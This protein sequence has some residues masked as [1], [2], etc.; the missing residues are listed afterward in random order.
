MNSYPKLTCAIAAILGGG[1]VG[2]AH[3]AQGADSEAAV[4]DSIEEVVVTAERRT[5][6]IQDVP[7][8]IQALTAET[9]TQ[10]DVQTMDDIVKFLPNVTIAGWGPGQG[11]I[12]MRGLSVGLLGDQSG[13]SIGFYPNVAI[14][15]DEQSG[16]MPERNLDIYAADLERVEV[17]EGPQGTLFGGSAE[18]G[19]V[20]YI[21][22][23]PKLDV[24]EG[25][26]SG[27]YGTTAH[28][29]PNSGM[30]AVLN[31]PLIENTLAVRG[32]IY[33][34]SRGGYINNVPGTFTRNCNDFG[35]GHA[36]GIPTYEN[37]C[38]TGA[39]VALGGN[40]SN[41][42]YPQIPGAIHWSNGQ[43]VANA[44]NPVTYTGIR[45]EALWKINDAWDVLLSQMNQNMNA[46]GVF[47]QMPKSDDGVPLGEWEVTNFVPTYDHDKF[48]ASSV[49]VNGLIGPLKALYSGGFVDRNVDQAGDYT[50]YSRGYAADYYNC[51]SHVSACYS[52]AAG[53]NDIT[54][55]TH[56]SHELRLSSPDDWRDR[57]VA[58]AY[59][60]ENHIH[61]M[62]N[63]EYR[64]NPNVCSA[65]VDTDCFAALQPY[66]GSTA[67]NPNPRGPSTSFFED[68][69]RTVRQYAFY[70]SDDFDIIPKVLTISA[71]TRYYN[72]LETEVGS[73]AYG[74]YC[75]SV[76]E[77]VCTNLTSAHNINA[78]H[79]RE[80][81]S[82]FKSRAGISWNRSSGYEVTEASCTSL[83]AHACKEYDK[84]L[85]YAP[86]SLIN[87]ELGMK[88]EWLDHRLQVNATVYLEKW[89]DAQVAFFDPAQFG[90]LTFSTNG[91]DYQV[92]GA[93]LQL[94]AR[95]TRGLTVQ[96][97]ASLNHSKQTNSPC[98]MDNNPLNNA[99]VGGYYGQCIP[100][101]NPFGPKGTSLAMSPQ[102]QGNL[103]ARYE[104]L[105]GPY[106]SFVQADAQYEGKN[107]SLV[108][109]VPTIAPTGSTT[110]SFEN[111]SYAL[112]D[113]SVGIAK[114]QWT[115]ELVG[116]NLANKDVI[117]FI[118]AAQAI[119]TQTV[120]RPRT[121]GVTVNY[122]F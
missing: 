51:N 45:V 100:G 122:K 116:H 102:F 24:T 115:A 62:T 28:G 60:E 105:M 94:I 87:N 10:L 76:P 29:D 83:V 99:A 110:Q 68:T 63:W 38:V 26:I 1:S 42:I 57:F 59:W 31:L 21:T 43:Q 27:S 78:D 93:E 92:E 121:V 58:G 16:Q 70:L 64:S 55:Q 52:P 5:E 53:W 7:I 88:S 113:A 89:T 73:Y 30:E 86:D 74:Y 98:L 90:T 47:Y 8:T 114:N 20:R 25:N 91:P 61:G 22:N 104:F 109:S 84:P 13:G 4:S 82:G 17:L 103:R 97:A 3:A 40:G 34:D 75:K 39:P 18:A 56:L 71:G 111:P 112:F 36:E 85:T 117:T 80:T 15:L 81:F 37:A 35:I 119:E 77:S 67:T 32:V 107:S 48:S 2:F 9:L 118:S 49:T 11:L 23:K 44:I 33:D 14:Y 46:G 54:H 41:S 79:D 66:P 96:G 120:G 72:Y 108:G 106:N 12:N 69:Q 95:P 101:I 19:V 50:A 65:T 6:N